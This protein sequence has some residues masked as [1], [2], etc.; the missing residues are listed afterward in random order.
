MEL[1]GSVNPE[2]A[3]F[4]SKI[5]F[6]RTDNVFFSLPLRLAWGGGLLIKYRA[7]DNN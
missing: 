2:F 7:H 1:M 6:S 4:H 3:P 5:V